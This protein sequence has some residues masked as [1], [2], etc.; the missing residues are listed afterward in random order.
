MTYGIEL[1]VPAPAPPP[2][3]TPTDA[4]LPLAEDVGDLKAG[5]TEDVP[6]RSRDDSGNID[7]VPTSREEVE[8]QVG[9]GALCAA[10]GGGGGGGACMR[11]LT[12]E[13]GLVAALW[14][15]LAAP[16]R[17]ASATA[18]CLGE[19]HLCAHDCGGF[20]PTFWAASPSLTPCLS[21]KQEVMVTPD[22]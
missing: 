14:P 8:E 1:Y 17:R 19:P 11:S 3:P 12:T 18:L 22:E 6:T 20:V 13:G 5:P 4:E 7:A 9:R 21:P 10:V 16:S 2:S 15:A